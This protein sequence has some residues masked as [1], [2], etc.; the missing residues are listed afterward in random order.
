MKRTILIIALALFFA[1]P[2]FAQT[3]TP[4]PPPIAEND[5]VV[6]ISTNLIQ[7]DVT[8]TDKKGKIIKDLKPEDFEIFENGKKQ[9]ITNFSFVSAERNQNNKE[10]EKKDE[11][12][13]D[14]LPEKVRPE[15]V[16]RTIALVVD[17]I[18][19]SFV[20]TY[21]VRRALKKFVDE[22]MQPGDL[23]AIIRTGAG[24]GALQQFTSDKRMLYAAIEK[25]RWNPTGI[26]RIGAFSPIEKKLETGVTNPL[27]GETEELNEEDQDERDRQDE[28]NQFR[29]NIFATGTL[30]AVNYIIRGMK[31][32]PGRKS[33]MLLS[34]GF[35]L[36]STDGDGFIRSNRVF[37]SVQKLIDLANRASVVVYTID[38]RGLQV[39]GLTAADDISGYSPTELDEIAKDRQRKLFDSQGGLIY[40][41]GQTG[42]LSFINSN[43]ISGNIG[44]MLNDQSYYLIG[45][46]P[47]GDTFD[48][49]KRRFND[50]RVKVKRDGV[51]VRYRSGFFG[52][53]DE[54]LED[55]SLTAT[56]SDSLLK[57]LA[58]PFA[59]NEIN[60]S[61]NALF[62]GD[63]EEKAYISTFLYFDMKDLKFE[64]GPDGK[65]KAIIDILAVSFGDN[66][67]VV[68][69][70]SKFYTINVKEDVYQEFLNEGF[71][72]YFTFPVKKSG[73]YQ[74]RVAVRDRS[75]D[76]I[77]SAS[78]FIEV[79]KLKKNRLTLS[80]IAI[81]SFSRKQWEMRS[82]P[83]A[84]NTQNA[85]RSFDSMAETAQRIFK[86][87]SVISYGYEIYN[88]RYQKGQQPQIESKLRI[89]RDG[90][91]IYEGKPS[92]VDLSGQTDFKI[93]RSG[94]AFALGEGMPPGDYILQVIVT[95]NLAKKRKYRTTTE[96][97]QFEVVE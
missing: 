61:M 73:A 91:I 14:L 93:I 59:I 89:F 28:L 26:G 18:T 62:R 16:R 96:F 47:D 55:P 43:D 12:A 86:R 87:G 42:G 8:V 22:Q 79:P 10:V 49:E 81:E 45:Y 19:L 63:A 1:L 23:V 88:S 67:M 92:P 48:P 30:G 3:P 65:K 70:I 53:S 13:I 46:Q 37:D 74:M 44:K 11:L 94:G 78:Q 4:T 5:D 2:V 58:S 90:E 27:T 39:T 41:A 20:S 34:D 75:S 51:K 72:Y 7:V 33:V 15:Q 68:D 69:E 80:G 57:A 97:V 21:Y 31:Q 9:E 6:K 82:D 83:N 60:L 40:L 32:L 76:K 52:I 25:V 17:D 95:D 29:E 66:G 64:D 56:T 84:D 85:K 77:G 24:I 36:V 71:V 38:A 50:L 35:S 54:T